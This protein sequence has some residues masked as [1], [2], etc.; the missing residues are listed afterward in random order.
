MSK[1]RIRDLK[2]LKLLA[3]YGLVLSSGNVTTLDEDINSLQ[4][5]VEDDV[6]DNSKYSDRLSKV[7]EG[8]DD[9]IKDY[10]NRSNLKVV[11]LDGKDSAEEV[12]TELMGY[13][14]GHITGFLDD[15]S[16]SKCIYVDSFQKNMGKCLHC[17]LLECCPGPFGSIE[18]THILLFVLLAT[19]TINVLFS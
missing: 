15:K 7:I 17:F 1:K 11:L 16:D 12:Y 13:S 9:G 14:S 2:R 8:L 6:R 18:K 3:M 4:T 19:F 10:I 5:G